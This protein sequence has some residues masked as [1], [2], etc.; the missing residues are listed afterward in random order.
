MA[1]LLAGMFLARI[2]P[3]CLLLIGS[4]VVALAVGVGCSSGD[5]PPLG[6]VSGT[7]TLD[8]ASLPGVVVSFAPAEGRSSM[9]ITD[10]AGRYELSYVGSVKGARVGSHRVRVYP[11]ATD[12]EDNTRSF[13]GPRI[14]ARY[15]AEST[16]TAEVRRGRNEFDFALESK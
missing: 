16:L 7:V 6:R 13:S 2:S 5:R 3:G 4:G 15:N 10:A 9:A 12:D 1:R 11:P 8:G 14:P